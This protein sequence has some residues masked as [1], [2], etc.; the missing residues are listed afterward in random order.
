[1]QT[2]LVWRTTNLL[3]LSAR[4]YPESIL[5]SM[6]SALGINYTKAIPKLKHALVEFVKLYDRILIA[7]LET[8]PDDQSSCGQF[9]L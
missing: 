7:T 2:N 6:V 5:G 3:M 4:F 9:E 1:M 8:T